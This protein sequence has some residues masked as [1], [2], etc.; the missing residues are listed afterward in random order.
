MQIRCNL[1]AIECEYD[2][3]CACV[4]FTVP[5]NCINHVDETVL[6]HFF[7]KAN[8]LLL[9]LFTCI[10]K[11][12]HTF[13][14]NFYKVHCNYISFYFLCR[15]A[16]MMWYLNFYPLELPINSIHITHRYWFAISRPLRPSFRLRFSVKKQNKNK[17]RRK[18]ERE[19]ESEM[20][21]KMPFTLKKPES[22][23]SRLFSAVY[24]FFTPFWY[25]VLKWFPFDCLHPIDC[26]LFHI[27][28]HLYSTG[29]SLLIK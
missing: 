17:N 20:N 13:D 5:C 4:H 19:R 7:P 23:R 11:H 26:F 14:A 2:L 18:Q 22:F 12:T 29:C 28:H 25:S 3:V 8:L 21:K 16:H 10:Y 6:R 27:L 24:L 15:A 9:C 1:F